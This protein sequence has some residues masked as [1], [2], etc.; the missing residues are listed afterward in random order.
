M[1]MPLDHC[2]SSS[3]TLSPLPSIVAYMHFKNK[4]CIFKKNTGQRERRDWHSR[5]IAVSAQAHVQAGFAVGERQFFFF[6]LSSCPL[7]AALPC[8]ATIAEGASFLPPSPVRRKA[9]AP[10]R[11]REASVSRELLATLWGGAGKSGVM[12]PVWTWA[13]TL[14][15]SL[16]LLPGP[17]LLSARGTTADFLYP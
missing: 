6:W 10:A 2:R 11:W 13:L 7:R 16:L 9:G 12:A 17:H 5:S 8:L 14:H 15:L 3:S 4:M 1:R